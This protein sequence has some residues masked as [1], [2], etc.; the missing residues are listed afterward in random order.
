[1]HTPPASKTLTLLS[2]LLAASLSAC[3]PLQPQPS[4]LVTSPRLPP[5]D[6][7]LMEP[8]QT[9]GSYS[10]SVERDLSTWADRLTGSP[11]K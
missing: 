2:L 6:P 10:E 1:M 9:P 4:V 7:R 3:A 5:P 11:P 8:P